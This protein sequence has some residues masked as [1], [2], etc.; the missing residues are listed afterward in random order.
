MSKGHAANGR[1]VLVMVSV[2]SG[3]I[4]D[5]GHRCGLNQM[6]VAANM[7]GGE[8]CVCTPDAIPDP[9]GNG[10]LPCGVNETAM[11]NKCVCLEGFSRAA[12]ADPCEESSIGVP[13]TEAS[14]CSGSFP[15]CATDASESYCTAQNCSA[16]SCPTGYACEQAADATYCG[17]LPA[18]LGKTCANDGDCAGGAAKSC[19]TF[20]SHTCILTG[21][22]NGELTCP[23]FYACCDV[24]ALLPGFSVCVP[25]TA[26]T[27]DGNCTVGTKVTP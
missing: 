20:M 16:T 24:S 26:L 6:V 13:C 5:D 21:C 10:C 27:A 1:A 9:R 12:E 11:N 18:G 17:K 23:G 19:D 2:A 22:A 7:L 3:C 8:I 25:P 15:Y 14:Q 4:V